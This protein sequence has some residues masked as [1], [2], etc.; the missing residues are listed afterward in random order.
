MLLS[1]QKDRHARGARHESRK[2]AILRLSKL[3][4]LVPGNVE[5]V[6]DQDLDTHAHTHTHTD[7][8]RAPHHTRVCPPPPTHIHPS[9]SA[10]HYQ[11]VIPKVILGMLE[12]HI[13]QRHCRHKNTCVQYAPHESY[14]PISLSVQQIPQPS[15]H[16]KEALF[17][18]IRSIFFTF[19]FCDT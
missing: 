19:S 13:H 16:N 17:F 5:V 2:C 6:E 4:S 8:R 10:P 12:P 3:R 1:L 14:V 11:K 9:A 7:A 15:Q 18:H